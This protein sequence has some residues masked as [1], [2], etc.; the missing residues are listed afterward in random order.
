MLTNR[1]L[2]TNTEKRYSFAEYNE[3]VAQEVVAY[4]DGLSDI[5][6][7][8]VVEFEISY[9][10]AELA[11]VEVLKVIGNEALSEFEVNEKGHLV[12][13]SVYFRSIYRNAFIKR[14]FHE[15]SHSFA[16]E[17]L[18]LFDGVL[19]EVTHKKRLI[20]IDGENMFKT[21]TYLRSMLTFSGD[22]N[23]LAER[24]T[25]RL[26][27]VCRPDDWTPEQ[28]GGYLERK[29]KVTTKKG[30]EQTSQRALD[31]LNK[32]QSL[33]WESRD[34]INVEY[35]Y[36]YDK[37]KAD[38]NTDADANDKANT[39]LLSA[40]ADYEAM[41]DKEFYF[42]WRFDHRGRMYP[43]GYNFNPQGNSIKKGSLK[44][45][46]GYEYL[47]TDGEEALKIYAIDSLGHDK[48]LNEE[49]IEMFDKNINE[50]K[51]WTIEQIYDIAESPLEF[52]NCINDWSANCRGEMVE[53]TAN[54]D[55]SNQALQ[56]Y[57]VLLKDI[58]SAKLS[59]M[60]GEDIRY[61]AY[62]MIADEMNKA[63]GTKALT[64]N[65]AKKPLMT[66]LYGK[67]RAG[68]FMAK[69]VAK[70]FNVDMDEATDMAI[71]LFDK[72]LK[73]LA[74]NALTLMNQL[75]RLHS[76]D[77]E[78]YGWNLPDG[79]EVKYDVKSEVTFNETITTVE[80]T[81][82]HINEE[83][84]VYG[85]KEK[86]AGMAPNIVHSVDG[87]VAR[88]LI[89]NND[90][91][92]FTT[93]DSFGAHYNNVNKLAKSYKQTLIS[94]LDSDLLKDII[95]DIEMNKGQTDVQ[96]IVINKGNLS[97]DMIMNSK[98]AVA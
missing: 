63:L 76:A 50:W 40:K 93:H 66:S 35:S 60:A 62:Q 55:A 49:K 75:Q 57:A 72:A 10:D 47:T 84:E 24:T 61:D 95:Q 64:R 29:R 69:A 89:L 22:T 5:A 15:Q 11:L 1:E 87:Y 73:K 81:R 91:P 14:L 53:G 46:V 17:M 27:L 67:A 43:T 96:G 65:D 38:G 41:K 33:A 36:L 13:L 82:V 92:V 7:K 51:G 79:F 31:A 58:Q 54:I 78:T 2:Q 59:N 16:I 98:Y 70:A 30:A 45:K 18:R 52:R 37:F 8:M 25:F 20:E 88:C 21:F 12:P 28:R 56:M 68:E 94:I 32:L 23:L 83:I 48:L 34:D 97:A 90:F 71:Q 77:I 9:E 19:F 74:P 86:S 26:P 39:I 6:N 42:E 4:A 44:A 80:G 3:S 85:K